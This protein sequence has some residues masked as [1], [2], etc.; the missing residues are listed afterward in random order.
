MDEMRITSKFMT[1]VISGILKRQV[2]KRTG[3]N[4]DIR[5]HD[6]HVNFGDDG[7]AHLKIDLEAT[8]D[9]AELLSILKKF[10]LY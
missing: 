7:K 6:V 10:D 8:M 3:Y 2:K 5:L 4:V 1:G 9:G